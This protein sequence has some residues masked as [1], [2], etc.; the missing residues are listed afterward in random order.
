MPM[1]ILSQVLPPVLDHGQDGHGTFFSSL[2][3]YDAAGVESS[4]NFYK[5]SSRWLT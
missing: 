1:A 3:Q 4:P 5:S 2:I